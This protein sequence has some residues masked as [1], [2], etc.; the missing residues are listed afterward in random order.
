MGPDVRAVIVHEDGNVAD[1]AN[2]ALAA[3]SVNRLPLL[4]ECE[5]QSALDGNLLRQLLPYLLQGFGTALCDGSRPF[6]PALQPKFL[7]QAGE[8]NEIFQP[9][10]VVAT[11]RF[12]T[13]MLTER[14]RRLLKKI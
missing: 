8:E 6:V 12:E 14:V 7:A 3:I 11:K 9:P 4:E 13:V 10:G 2:A 1:D 5:L